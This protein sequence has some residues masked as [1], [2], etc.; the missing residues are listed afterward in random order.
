MLATTNKT[1]HM[2]FNSGHTANE[3]GAFLAAVQPHPL[4]KPK[5]SSAT[6]R[7]TPRPRKAS[8]FVWRL[9][10]RTSRGRRTISPI[11]IKLTHVRFSI[12]TPGELYIPSSGRMHDGLASLLAKCRLEVL[13]IVGVQVIARDRLTTVLVDSL[14]NLVSGSVAQTGE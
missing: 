4:Y 8:G 13:A 7:K 5:P 6:I 9:I 3:P 1:S 11:P 10:L 14:K 12:F 2:A